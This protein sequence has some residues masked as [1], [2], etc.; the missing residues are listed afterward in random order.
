MGKEFEI[1]GVKYRAGKMNAFTQLHIVRRL[2]PVLPGLVELQHVD[3]K[4]DEAASISA[5]ATALQNIRDEDVEYVINACLDVTERRNPGGDGWAKVRVNGATMFTVGLV[6]MLKIAMEA[7]QENLADFFG[8]YRSLSS[9]E[10]TSTS[11][12]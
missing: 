3:W 4:N 10:G 7:V 9:Q 5:L 12:G 11:T 8:A 1:G 6:D 2:L